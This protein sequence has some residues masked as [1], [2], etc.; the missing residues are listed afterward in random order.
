MYSQSNHN[1]SHS[2]PLNIS[3]VSFEENSRISPSDQPALKK[4]P[5]YDSS[6]EGESLTPT[7]SSQLSDLNGNSDSVSPRENKDDK[8]L[9]MAYQACYEY[10]SSCQQFY[11]RTQKSL[12]KNYTT[13]IEEK[14]TS[15]KNSN[16]MWQQFTGQFTSIVEP[17]AVQLPAVTAK[18]TEEEKRQ[19]QAML[20]KKAY[21]ESGS[22]LFPT[23]AALDP[24]AQRIV[25]ENMVDMLLRTVQ[26][27][28]FKKNLAAHIQCVSLQKDICAL[29]NPQ[30]DGIWQKLHEEQHISPYL[31][32]SATLI[33]PVQYL[34]RYEMLLANA[35]KELNK[36]AD[37]SK[38]K[39]NALVKQLKE[40]RLINKRMN[41]SYIHFMPIYIVLQKKVSELSSATKLDAEKTAKLTALIKNMRKIETAITNFSDLTPECLLETLLNDPQIAL[42]TGKVKKSSSTADELKKIQQKLI[43]IREE[44]ASQIPQKLKDANESLTAENESLTKQIDKLTTSMLELQNQLTDMQSRHLAE[45]NEL[46]KKLHEAHDIESK[47]QH[48]DLEA[49]QLEAK[50]TLEQEKSQYAHNVNELKLQLSIL[51][52]QLNDENIAWQD[53][54]HKLMEEKR[55]VEDQV[56]LLN[57]QIQQNN[58]R[59]AALEQ[60]VVAEPVNPPITEENENAFEP[61]I[62]PPQDN[63][64]MAP[65]AIDNEEMAR[66][67]QENEDLKAQIKTQQETLRG[68]LAQFKNALESHWLKWLGIIT[69]TAVG[70]GLLFTGV[71][72]LAGLGLLAAVSYYTAIGLTAG[73]AV[74]LSA[75]AGITLHHQNQQSKT[76]E[77]ALNTAETQL[78]KEE[79]F[80]VV[81]TSQQPHHAEQLA[82]QTQPTHEQNSV[83]TQPASDTSPSAGRWFSFL[84][85]IG[86]RT[87]Q[88]L[89]NQ[90]EEFES[91][92]N[93]I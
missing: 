35:I 54:H 59:I 69:L 76:V 44:Q 53:R 16:F 56:D 67:R 26:S 47:K 20:D 12:I 10:F 17:V 78:K 87:N 40:I 42:A 72:S 34:P 77:D 13:E 52:D 85:N 65:A 30:L 27:E 37:F 81:E 62:A 79:A 29:I 60:P 68:A 36:I 41:E 38:E 75:A 51:Q 6:D 25:L 88:A 5:I 80:V 8:N 22:A 74:A 83:V 7:E 19:Y 46:E 4:A 9:L 90:Y 86:S 61:A 84:R 57:E 14:E 21:L 92:K 63:L 70:L 73:G 28:Q 11:L 2:D 3:S 89:P 15:K 82:A 45:K 91:Y 66:L 32:L 18:S 55:R 1:K 49:F 43:K 48:E 24:V 93:K 71:G 50:R 58:Q 64:V 39:K 31:T 33:E 23:A